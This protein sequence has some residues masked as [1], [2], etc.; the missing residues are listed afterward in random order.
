M[1]NTLTSL[2]LAG[3]VAL[4][5]ASVG[6][7]KYKRAHVSNQTEQEAPLVPTPYEYDTSWNV[8]SNSVSEVR[9]DQSPFLLEFVV[10]DGG[11][12]AVGKAVNPRTN[13]HSNIILYDS[14]HTSLVIDDDARKVE[15]L[16]TR[17][18]VPTLVTNTQGELMH[19]AKLTASGPEAIR[20]KR[21]A[22]HLNS[23][24]VPY[25]VVNY[26]EADVDYG[27]STLKMAGEEFY[28]PLTETNRTNTL[29][30]YLIPKTGTK[31]EITPNGTI[32]LHS[33]GIYSLNNVC[34]KDYFA[35]TNENAVNV[36]TNNLLQDSDNSP[37]VES[38][39][40]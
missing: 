17:V 22:I 30:F 2:L 15:P 14:G 40:R 33:K 21:Q 8:K 16:S 19:K 25:G 36:T 31:R 3:T 32:V 4:S 27:I 35:R 5:G 28:A 13:E 20:T 29:N 6:C 10:R 11:Q 34:A 7:N 26:T 37:R 1:K 24:G 12:Y 9:G 18:Y 38:L 39:S 23:G